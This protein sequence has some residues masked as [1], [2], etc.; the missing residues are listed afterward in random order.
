[1]ESECTESDLEFELYSQT[2]YGCDETDLPLSSYHAIQESENDQDFSKLHSP[3]NNS[4]CW[5]DII[6]SLKSEEHCIETLSVT[7]S[8]GSIE[9][10]EQL[11][12]KPSDCIDMPGIDLHITEDHASSAS[13]LK[14][15]PKYRYYDVCKTKCRKCGKIG[16][17]S[18]KCMKSKQ[19]PVCYFCSEVGHIA[20]NCAFNKNQKYFKTRDKM[21]KTSF[22]NPVVSGK[23]QAKS[24]TVTNVAQNYKTSKKKQQKYCKKKTLLEH[25]CT[26]GYYKQ[27]EMK[28]FHKAFHASKRPAKKDGRQRN[29]KKLNKVSQKPK[30][31]CSK[32]T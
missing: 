8:L 20:K 13:I 17:I 29:K 28:S 16:H 27:R 24:Y 19:L 12:V 23:Q 30:Q 31:K 22:K 4:C 9:D 3:Q 6:D 1:M 26:E 2:H 32:S 7:S 25:N 5:L 21:V 15:Q 10:W 18:A 14:T 11:D